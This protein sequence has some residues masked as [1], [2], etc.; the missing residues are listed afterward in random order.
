MPPPRSLAVPFIEW[1]EFLAGWRWLQGEHLT[2][3]GPTGVGKSTLH[4]AVLPR[5]ACVVVFGTKVADPTLDRYLAQG[6]HRIYRWPP[7]PWMDRVILWPRLK[8]RESLRQLRP[9]FAEAMESIFVQKRWTVVFDELNYICQTLGLEAAVKD[10]MHQ[11]RSLGLTIVSGTQRP[12]WVPPITYSSASHAFVWRTGDDDDARKL[13][14]L[15]AADKK[16]VRDT[17]GEMDGHECLYIP[18]R[19]GGAMVRTIVE[20]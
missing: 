6:Y 20:P 2:V 11:G 1:G 19:I 13:A 12:A 5:R 18:T 15:G 7:P 4:Q 14:G 9:I 8:S 3:L 16:L 10:F 17:L